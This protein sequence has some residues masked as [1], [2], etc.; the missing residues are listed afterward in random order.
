LTP[1]TLKDVEEARD[2]I[3]PHLS[4]TPFRNY[5]P[6][7]D[8]VGS[9]IRV[10]VKHENHQP[11]SAFKVRNGLSAVAA[12]PEAERR[13]GLIAASTGNHGQGL[14]WAGERLRAPVTICVPLGNNP[15]KNRAMRGYG[16][17]LVEEGADYD[18]AVG[19]AKRLAESEGLTTVHSTNN[20]DVIAGAGTIA[21]EMAEQEPDLDA[22]V[23]AIG[24]GSQAVGA[25]TVMGAL[26]PGVLVYGVQ[27]SRAAACHDSWHARKP[28]AGYRSQTMADGLATRSTYEFTFPA[29][30][31]GLAGFV[32]VEEGELAEGVRTLLAL[33][34]NL[35]E[36]AG[37][38]GLAG[39][40]KLRETLR[41][42]RVGII[43]SGGNADM[44]VLSEIVQG[45]L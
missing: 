42:K 17:R 13:R 8:Y 9:G 22:L 7:D 33:A 44:R 10:F 40:L 25:L 12:L 18:E 30:L 43:L 4:P 11:T 31:E 29:L 6:L 24:G 1:L 45:R 2:R 14:A 28:L 36:P 37:A 20:R 19:V 5:P 15:E 27:A 34:H 41:G 23:V 16:A 21:L 26:R 3:R 35:A 39:L 38:A 32:A